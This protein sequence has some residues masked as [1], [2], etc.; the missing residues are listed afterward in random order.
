MC[1]CV[2]RPGL[3]TT[4]H[5]PTLRP[6]QEHFIRD[7]SEVSSWERDAEGRISLLEVVKQ[8]KPTILIGCSTMSGAFDEE[9][10]REMAK[11]VERPIVFPLSSASPSLS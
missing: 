5:S 3:L 9:V 10:V 7:A 8:A 6:G 11:H 2:D 4:E 1:R